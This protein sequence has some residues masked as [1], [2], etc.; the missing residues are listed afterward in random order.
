M[1]QIGMEQ[2][3]MEQIGMERIGMERIGAGVEA[4]ADLCS[5]RSGIQERQACAMPP[6]CKVILRISVG[7]TG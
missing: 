1:E 3:G 2:I 5:D 6:R 4:A 7:F